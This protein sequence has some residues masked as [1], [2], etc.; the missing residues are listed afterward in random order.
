MFREKGWN[1]EKE[2]L[3]HSPAW[4]Q[5]AGWIDRLINYMSITAQKRFSAN[6]STI[7]EATGL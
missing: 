6:A 7:S 4:G 2:I 5:M 3:M 1:L